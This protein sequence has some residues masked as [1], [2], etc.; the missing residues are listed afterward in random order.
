M[1]DSIVIA[2]AKATVVGI[3]FDS[4]RARLERIY[5]C[6]LILENGYQSTELSVNG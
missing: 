4:G 3:H 5:N 6:L 1:A 2:V